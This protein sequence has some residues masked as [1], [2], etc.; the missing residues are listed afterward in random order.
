M[1]GCFGFTYTL[2]GSFKLFIY[3]WG[4]ELNTGPCACKYIDL[5]LES[6]TSPV[7]FALVSLEMG[8]LKL[9]AWTTLKP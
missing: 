8:F 3:L 2:F 5:L 9:F 6:H 7:H 1:M 4:W